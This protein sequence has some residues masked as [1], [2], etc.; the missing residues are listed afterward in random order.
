MDNSFK[1]Q[2]DDE[3]ISKDYVFYAKQIGLWESEK[4]IFNTF[5]KKHHKILDLGCGAGR[6][7]IPLFMQG[8]KNIIGIDISKTAIKNAKKLAR[9]KNL[10]INFLQQDVLNL[11]FEPNQFDGAIFSFNG[12]FC[13]PKQENRLKALLE[14]KRVLKPNAPLIFTAHNRELLKMFSSH[15]RQE[16]KLWQ[17]NKQD[18]RLHDFGDF[19]VESDDGA[20]P[21]FLHMPTHA[22]VLSL[23]KQAGFSVVYTELRDNIAKTPAVEKLHFTLCRFYVVAKQ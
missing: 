19:I 15:F 12:L 16:K 3:Q 8:F 10:S 1:N 18:K 13:I 11:N 6:T 2:Y 17:N 4:I 5:L 23:I 7:T 21:L 22:E 20:G 9:E 14:I